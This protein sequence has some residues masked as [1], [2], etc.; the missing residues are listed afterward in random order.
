[1]EGY[2]RISKSVPS[3]RNCRGEAH[4]V[5]SV[6]VTIIKRW[7]VQ[8]SMIN[9]KTVNQEVIHQD[10][11]DFLKYILSNSV[12]EKEEGKNDGVLCFI[13]ALSII[14]RT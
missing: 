2:L 14:V 8:R 11:G 5:L 9:L 12:N 7:Y 10:M 3:N 13:F 4:H 6:K 1:M